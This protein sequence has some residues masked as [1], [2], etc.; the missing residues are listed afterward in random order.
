MLKPTE[1]ARFFDHTLLK[2]EATTAQVRKLVEEA[3][4]Y[5]FYGVCV[6][7]IHVPLAVELVSDLTGIPEG[8]YIEEIPEPENV[9]DE[10]PMVI[11]EEEETDTG[12]A[13]V[14]VIDFPLGA[15]TAL[16][17][18][19]ETEKVVEMGVDE[20]DMVIPIGYLKEKNYYMVEKHIAEVIRAAGGEE[21]DVVVKV[22]LETG[23][24][25]EDEKKVAAAIAMAA[26]ADFVKTSTGFLGGGA[27]VEDVRLLRE[28]VGPYKGVKASGGIRTAEAALKMIEAGANRLGTSRTVQIMEQYIALYHGEDADMTDDGQGY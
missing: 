14:A 6:N 15:G 9:A 11:E 24:L 17:K 4:H 16:M 18:A 26:G 8:E 7:P 13:V 23:L 5:G 25:T 2:P 3:Y 12:V 19:Y 20:V 22:I 10:F 1:F 27:T 21:R 28:V